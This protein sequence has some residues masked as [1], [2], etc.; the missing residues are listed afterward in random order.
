MLHGIKST[1]VDLYWGEIEPFVKSALDT[2]CGDYSIE[3]VYYAIKNQDMQL[4]AWVEKDTIVAAAIT[5]IVIYPLKKVCLIQL[6]GGSAMSEWKNES[7]IEDWA[8]AHGCTEMEIYG[9][10][11]WLRALKDWKEVFTHFR[12]RL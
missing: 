7:L 9:R 5:S 12:K 6:A 1:Y 10:R 11:G 3:N 4:W 2:S 8:T